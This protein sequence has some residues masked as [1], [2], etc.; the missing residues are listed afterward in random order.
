MIIFL[1]SIDRANSIGFFSNMVHLT[2]SHP[3]G[4]ITA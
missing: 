3:I 2:Q 1:E 4:P